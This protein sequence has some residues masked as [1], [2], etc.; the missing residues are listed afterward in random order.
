MVDAVLYL[1]GERF[2]AVPP[3]A[4]HQE[5]LRADPRGRRVRDARRGDG[6]G[7]RT[8]R[9]RSW[10]SAA[11]AATGSAVTVTMEG[12]RPMLRRG[13][14]AGQPKRR[15]RCRAAP[16]TAS[17]PTACSLVTA[18]LESA[19]GRAAARPGPVR[20]RHRRPARRR[21][22]GR[23]GGGAGDRFQ[24]PG[25]ARSARR[26]S[27]ASSACPASCAA[28]GSSSSGCARR[29]SSA[30]SGRSCRARDG[31]RPG[32]R[33]GDRPGCDAPRSCQSGADV[34]APPSS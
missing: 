23:P 20:E 7:A 32:L 18:V 24:L 25:P 9:R 5:P 10:P 30:S 16:A 11:R 17:I 31:A 6:R 14:G 15:W 19:A 33:A 8:P 26:W 3:A 22:G 21:A 4:Q 2:H 1:E 29:P 34:I 13:S 28:S 12:T 27:R